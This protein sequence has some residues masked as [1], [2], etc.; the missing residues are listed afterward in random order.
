MQ[1]ETI[2]AKAKS[3]KSFLN[4]FWGCANCRVSVHH[5]RARAIILGF[6]NQNFGDFENMACFREITVMSMPGRRKL[7]LSNFF[8]CLPPTRT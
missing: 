5:Y 7:G 8:S 2:K 6:A 3:F 4:S 1:I